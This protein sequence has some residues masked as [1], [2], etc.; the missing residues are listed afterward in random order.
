M[1]DNHPEFSRILDVN[2]VGNAVK[3]HKLIAKPEER[4]AL[5]KRF[6]ILALDFFEAIY[7][8]EK[9]PNNSFKIVGQLKAKITQ[10]CVATADPVEEKI[11][12]DFCLILRPENPK[13]KAEQ[14]LD[15]SSL[16]VESEEEIEIPPNGKIDM[17]EV[18][19]Q[20]LS[21]SLNPYPRK[22]DSAF[23]H[24]EFEDSSKS[25]P[26]DILKDLK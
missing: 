6:N 22:E 7:T 13:P 20:Y 24:K 25:N 3:E 4:K 12:E 21:L 18:F 17:G 14:D 8:V 10:A 15:L 9:I 23:S 2:T 1:S 16:S 5:V 19:A 11:M 26:F